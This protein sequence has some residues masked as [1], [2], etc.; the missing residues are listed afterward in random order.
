MIEDAPG[1]PTNAFEDGKPGTEARS[2]A[3]DNAARLREAQSA[4][5]ESE[6]RYRLLFNAIDA[7]FCT[8][9]MI[10]DEAGNPVDFRY[11]DVNDGFEKQTGRR[12]RPGE[13]M[14]G[15]FPEAEH[16][17][18][19]LYAKVARTGE[20]ER[21]VDFVRGLDR[22]YDVYVFPVPGLRGNRLGALFTDVTAI[23]RAEAALRESEERF[24]TLFD[25]IDEG[26]AITEM[27]YDDQ[28]EIVDMIYRQVNAAFERQGGI[29]NAAGRSIF[30][31]LPGVEQHWL[32]HYKQVARTGQ[33]VRV[34]N[35]QQ[36]VDRWF[37]VYFTRVDEEGRF[38][39][40]VFNDISDR[41][42]SEQS[43]RE[44]EGRLARALEAGELG[45]WELDLAT[46]E[47]WRSPQHDRIF[48]YATLL[49]EWT[50]DMFLDHVVPEDRPWVDERFQDAIAT[51]G[52]WDFECRIRGADGELRWIWAQGRVDPD[53]EG[54]PARMK[55]TVRDVT[56]RKRSEL[57]LRESEAKYR[58]LFDSIDEAFCIVEVIPRS[59]GRAA[60]YRLL[61]VN[62]AFERQTG[63]TNVVG[64]LGSE[65][66]GGT[67]DHWADAYEKVM[68]T[69]EAVRVESH[70]QGTGH[71]YD[72]FMTRVG[73]PGSRL[74]CMVFQATTERREREERQRFLLALGDA[75]R[76][77]PDAQ[78]IIEAAARLLAERLSPSRVLFA[79]FDEANGYVEVVHAWTADGAEPFPTVVRQED[80]AGPIL[81][82]LRAGRMLRVDDA[83]DVPAD[84]P[85]LAALAGAGIMAALSVPLIIGGRLMATLSVH[86]HEA[87]HWTDA[88][89]SL[90]QEVAE[91][92]WADV[93]RARA[94]AALRRSEERLRRVLET[95][96]VGVLF[97]NPEG[98]LIDAN[99]AFLR[100]TG[101]T[102]EQVENRSL[103]WHR[104]TPPEWLQASE[105]QVEKMKAT[106][107]IGPYEKEYFRADGSKVW[108]LFAGRDL[109]GGTFVE[110]AID[111][112]DRKKA[113]AALRESEERLRQFG[114]AS[115]DILWIRDAETL[116]WN[117]LTAAFDTIYG[118]SRE[119][120]LTGDNYRN[121]LDLI[122][123]EDR[124]QAD[125]EIQR[126]R[127]GQPTV[128]EYRVRR[129]SDG[130]IRWLRNTDFPIRDEH[131][132]VTMI[133][134]I[135]ADVTERKADQERL[136]LLVGEL[137]HR[138]RN[139]LAVVRSIARRTAHNSDDVEEMASHLSGRLDA[140]A[141]VQSM[142]TRRP[143]AGVHLT[144]LIEEELLAYATREGEHL[145]IRGPDIVLETRPAETIS[146][147]IH[148]LTTNAVKYG[149]LAAERGRV[150]VTWEKV[151]SRV[152]LVWEE[153]G[154]PH[155][156]EAAGHEGFGFELLQRVIPYE[157]GAE[158][159]VDIRPQGLRF[160][161]SMPIDGNVR[162]EPASGN[163]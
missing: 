96:T 12:P 80:F 30:E 159:K 20:A 22:W 93:V 130:A 16:M 127:D 51:G 53:P 126:A 124:E 121:W 18:L 45:A 114:E 98:V 154:L 87:R 108:M 70:H 82:D 62:Q 39:A 120:A 133:G 117:Y 58:T 102:R 59:E 27:I 99:D 131:G 46:L 77:Q 156:A 90:L 5:R 84:R 115:Q 19:D 83:G 55:G 163:R 64:K 60:D 155:P 153:S 147:A 135:G 47:A 52:H 109:G 9:E 139:T 35:H 150:D 40:T 13:T 28:G 137:Q 94:E 110:F 119:E 149:A 17:W 106:G 160:R 95:D 116:Q 85:D 86:Q 54:R 148:E 101:Y 128:F 57:A 43:L 157:L 132:R 37:D 25:S 105:E 1:A 142:V 162:A 111:V 146:L 97:F 92:L 49:P 138:V 81:D 26:F 151:D 104:M 100:I 140:F 107:R 56:E 6:E 134:G 48:G 144:A 152:E 129:P 68:L 33:S 36:D 50:Y 11:V 63:L 72:V 10:F 123:P 76:A 125:R 8:F 42:R 78:S 158:T 161:L 88:E 29:Q 122:V 103:D 14:R 112:T 79:E 23:K 3:E 89:V 15:V 7:G 44:S 143:E 67:E 145:R 65:V 73:G 141:R 32:D 113:E 74:V 21:F 69:G 38:V 31:M 136:K 41:K 2:T 75:M 34:Q 71:W 118:I 24:R 66:S 91:R 4:L 61:E